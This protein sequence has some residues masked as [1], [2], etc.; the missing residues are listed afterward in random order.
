[1]WV[2]APTVTMTEAV[3]HVSQEPVTGNENV[4]PAAPSTEDDKVRVTDW[5][6]PPWA[7]AY[8]TDSRYVPAAGTPDTS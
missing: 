1:M 4:G 3:D 5:P 8:R 6:S 7:L 2:P